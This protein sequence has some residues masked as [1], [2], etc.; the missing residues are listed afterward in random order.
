LFYQKRIWNICNPSTDRVAGSDNKA[1]YENPV[2]TDK[3]AEE[4]NGYVVIKYIRKS[5]LEF[6][7]NLRGPRTE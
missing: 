7:N 2:A 1:R 3:K 6:V 5:V 4:E